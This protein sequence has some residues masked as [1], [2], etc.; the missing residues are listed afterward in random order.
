MTS[1]HGYIRSHIAKVRLPMVK[2]HK[3]LSKCWVV[4][5][6]R[7]VF[8]F[9]Y[10]K[11]RSEWKRYWYYTCMVV[12]DSQTLKI[13][14]LVIENL[15]VCNRLETLTMSISKLAILTLP[16]SPD[17]MAATFFLSNLW[18]IV[19]WKQILHAFVSYEF[20][21]VISNHTMY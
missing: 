20:S 9:I 14:K 15:L 12:V 3:C 5:A 11:Q 7:L 19:E 13:W 18:Y 16:R 21:I 8:V 1:A 17:Q 6:I 10:K 2:T 4:K